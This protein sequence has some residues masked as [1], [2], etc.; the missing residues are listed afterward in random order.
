M[1]SKICPVCNSMH[2]YNFFSK[3]N[4]PTTPNLIFDTQEDAINTP[5][6]NLTL[7]ICENCDFVFNQSFNLSLVNYGD[8]YKNSQNSSTYFKN[9]ISNLVDELIKKYNIR[10]SKILEIGCGDGYFLKQ[11]VQ[12]D[13][14]KN[15]GVGYDPSNNTTET[16]KRIRIEKSFFDDTCKEESDFTISR[17]VIEHIPNPIHFL[18]NIRKISKPQTK[19][20]FETPTV[21]WILKNNVFWDF[22]YEHCSLFSQNSMTTAF[23]IA[24]FKVN[25]IKSVFKDQYLWIEAVPSDVNYITKNSNLLKLAKS[26]QSLVK[27]KENE[28]KSK[29]EKLIKNGN[30]AFWGAAG[31]GVSLANIIDPDRKSIECLIDLNPEKWK[32]FIPGTGHDIINFTEIEK[33]KIKTAIVMNPNYFDEIKKFIIEQ[34]ININLINPD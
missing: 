9:Y 3:T 19:I 14:W 31:R 4:V 12:N 8:N 2:L 23:Q 6:G 7:V 27:Q 26:F 25:S 29:L 24:G 13:S 16:M 30:I 28:L 21:E 11:L 20:F 17:H 22:G 34:N 32:K 5:R 33:R 15:F 1:I 10:D 18:K